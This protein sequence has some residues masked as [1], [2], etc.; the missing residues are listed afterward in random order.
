VKPTIPP[1]LR[2]PL[3]ARGM[4]F[5]LAAFAARSINDAKLTRP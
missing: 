4:T 2:G 3:P 1:V 5:A